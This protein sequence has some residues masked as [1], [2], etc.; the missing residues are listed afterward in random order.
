MRRLRSAVTASLDLKVNMMQQYGLDQVVEELKTRGVKAGQ[1]AAEQLLQEAKT[2]AEGI[3]AEARAQAEA[4]KEQAKAEKQKPL[5]AMKAE[6]KQAARVGLTAFR[7]SIENSFLVPEV[8]EA[9]R[10]V[11]G[12]PTFLETAILEMVKG[13]VAS[14]MS[15]SDLV[16]TLPENRREELSGAFLNKLME[17]GA[18][19]VEVRFDDSLSFGFRVGPEEGGFSFDLSED[20][21]REILVKFLSPRF[22]EAFYKS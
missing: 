14:G 1:E 22:R 13:F 18:K 11:T 17:R 12:R 4:L 20:G 7:E 16:V 8:N 19:G 15:A 9:V 10:T 3:V 5:A 21:F 6:M 2:R